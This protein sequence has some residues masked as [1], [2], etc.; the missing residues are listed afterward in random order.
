MAVIVSRS[1]ARPAADES[2]AISP[3]APNSKTTPMTEQ[4]LMDRRTL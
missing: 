1:D 3:P 4:A 2:C